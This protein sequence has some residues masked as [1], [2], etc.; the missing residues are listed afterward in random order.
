LLKA[1]CQKNLQDIDDAI[2][3]LETV[4]NLPSV[5]DGI[6]VLLKRNKQNLQKIVATNSEIASIYLE[7]IEC[8]NLRKSVDESNNRM[9]EALKMF[10][11][12]VEEPKFILATVQSYISS[13]NFDKALNILMTI[14]PNQSCFVA[15]KSKMAEIYLKHK[16][17]VKNYAKC[18]SE[19]VQKKPTVDACVLLGDAYM[20][21]QEV[22]FEFK[23]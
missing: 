15:A 20:N 14:Q 9:Q 16:N 19:I 6:N 8:H 18:Y 2:I 17:D 5:K 22:W 4:L 23:I 11:G 10:E 21:I 1:I 3:T 13:G 7:L 12:S